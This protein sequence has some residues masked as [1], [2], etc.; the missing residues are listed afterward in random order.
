MTC[1]VPEMVATVAGPLPLNGTWAILVPVSL[2][3]SSAAR[4]GLLPKP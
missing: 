1:V 3:K 2:W 4:C